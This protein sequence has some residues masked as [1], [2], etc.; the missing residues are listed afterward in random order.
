VINWLASYP[1]SGNTWV[2]LFLTAYL[3]GRVDINHPT[4]TEFDG[5]AYLHKSL[6]PSKLNHDSA[7]YLRHAV[8]L[9]LIAS[10][11]INPLIVKSHWANITVG[12]VTAIPKPLTK[13]A[14]YIIRDPR[15]VCCS[16]S[17]HLAKP[18]DYTIAEMNNSFNVTWKPETMSC[19]WLKTWSEH[20]ESWEALEDA[21]IIKYEEMLS[22]P[23]EVFSAILDKY[24][25]NVRKGDVK[26]ALALTNIERLKKQEAKNGFVE[27]GNQD[28]FFGQG[29]GW[30]EELTEKQARRIC[31]D[32]RE[33][34]QKYGYIR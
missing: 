32:H 10:R 11:R 27:L 16:F 4:I 15:D 2:R 28:V 34:M 29:K 3:T 9:H 21:L 20:I 19:S 23:V 17:K 8:L 6:A 22:D 26:K 25:I 13:S 5:S 30:K 18:I 24:G 33:V 31:E 7:I 12:G 1:K 14:V